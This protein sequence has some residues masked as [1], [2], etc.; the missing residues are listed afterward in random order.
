MS[1]IFQK[2]GGTP[3]TIRNPELSNEVGRRRSQARGRTHD[4][5]LVVGDKGVTLRHMRLSFR[6]LT[7]TEKTNLETF[8]DDDAQGSLTQ[9][10]YTDHDEAEHTARFLNEG[11]VFTEALDARFHLD[12]ELEIES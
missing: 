4:G 9:F 11:L 8:F 10:T 12:V 3:Y 7:A 6:F 2:S 5:A 1:V